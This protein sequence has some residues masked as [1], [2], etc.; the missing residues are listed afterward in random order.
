MSP[1]LLKSASTHALPSH[2]RDP[3]LRRRCR[4]Q[5]RHKALA[6]CPL[7]ILAQMTCPP[8]T[9][10]PMRRTVQS[11]A[12]T[13]N[14]LKI[15]RLRLTQR[16]ILSHI[17]CCSPHLEPVRDGPQ[18]WPPPPPHHPTLCCL[19]PP[20]PRNRNRNHTQLASTQIPCKHVSLAHVPH[21]LTS[22][23]SNNIVQTSPTAG[24]P[25]AANTQNNDSAWLY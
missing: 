20:R 18:G 2:A 9:N 1:R 17:N 5:R 7:S 3:A 11:R 16:T 13:H 21:L 25:E 24:S 22:F 15:L 19:L 14:P 6:I 4:I 23:H 12:T 8:R 10:H